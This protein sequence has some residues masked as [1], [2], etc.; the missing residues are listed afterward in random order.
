MAAALTSVQPILERMVMLRENIQNGYPV[1][2]K[3]N[4]KALRRSFG[5]QAVLCNS[6]IHPS[7]GGRTNREP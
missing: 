3:P 2:S 6:G 5:N 7:N 4:C 1:G